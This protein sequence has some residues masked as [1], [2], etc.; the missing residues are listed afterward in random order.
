MATSGTTG[1]R[2]LTLTL[3]LVLQVQGAH[4]A[5]QA[6][7]LGERQAIARE[8]IRVDIHGLHLL[9]ACQGAA[10][11]SG[12]HIQACLPE[13]PPFGVVLRCGATDISF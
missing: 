1:A 8:A 3:I 4:R 6:A 11:R 10:I 12:L 13:V 9:R 7:I 2:I 5:I